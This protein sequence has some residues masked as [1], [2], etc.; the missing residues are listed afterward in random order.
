MSEKIMNPRNRLIQNLHLGV[1]ADEM[2]VIERK[3]KDL[4]MTRT[5]FL[6]TAIEHFTGEKIFR[7]RVYDKRE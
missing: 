5:D 3:R 7:R 1:T 4:G 2:E 6:R